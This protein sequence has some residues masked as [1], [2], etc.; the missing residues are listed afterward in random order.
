MTTL[1]PVFAFLVGMLGVTVLAF[2]LR[3]AKAAV[4]DQRLQ[5]VKR[6]PW[7]S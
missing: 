2:I 6:S 7:A 5:E 4:I 1:F 3:P